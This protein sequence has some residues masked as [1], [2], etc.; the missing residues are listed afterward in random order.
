MWI[1][2]NKKPACIDLT[3]TNKPLRFENIYVIETG[4]F[5]FRKMRIAV[6]KMHFPKM[7]P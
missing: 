6:M 1:D 4:L 3:L 2:K 7:R 5:D